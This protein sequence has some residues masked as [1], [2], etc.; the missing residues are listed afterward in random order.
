MLHVNLQVLFHGCCVLICESNI[1]LSYQGPLALSDLSFLDSL[2]LYSF[3]GFMGLAL[4]FK[5]IVTDWAPGL[6]RIA[7]LVIIVH[8]HT[9]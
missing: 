1:F 3:D 6:A 9:I 4:F 2:P 7:I 8:S 5:K